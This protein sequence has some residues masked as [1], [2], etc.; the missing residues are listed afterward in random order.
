MNPGYL[1]YVAQ[2]ALLWLCPGHHCPAATARPS[3]DSSSSATP[4]ILL[5]N[6]YIVS[7]PNSVTYSLQAQNKYSFPAFIIFIVSIIRCS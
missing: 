6:Q 5:P 7:A 1:A 4:I 3:Y 2:Q